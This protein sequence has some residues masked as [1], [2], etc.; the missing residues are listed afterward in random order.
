M[1]YHRPPILVRIRI[2][3]SIFDPQS[4]YSPLD[5]A[6]SNL[7]RIVLEQGFTGC[8]PRLFKITRIGSVVNDDRCGQGA[9]EDCLDLLRELSDLILE[10]KD[11]GLRAVSITRCSDDGNW[12]IGPSKFGVEILSEARKLS[13]AISRA[14]SVK[15]LGLKIGLSDNG[16][17]G[18]RGF[19]PEMGHPYR[20]PL[21]NM[22]SEVQP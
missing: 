3:Y 5:V 16:V 20:L 10:P 17:N 18:K 7:N 14:Q 22:I 2:R 9:S 6:T 8:C 19:F 13:I 15:D 1:R 12:I 11:T 21:K 4:C